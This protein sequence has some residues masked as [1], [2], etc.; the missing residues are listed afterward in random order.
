MKLLII[1]V[2]D[3]DDVKPLPLTLSAIS[4][5]ARMFQHMKVTVDLNLDQIDFFSQE[6]T[7]LERERS[8]SDTLSQLQL[9]S[10]SDENVFLIDLIT[11]TRFSRIREKH[12]TSLAEALKQSPDTLAGAAAA[13]TC[14]ADTFF[15]NRG[16]PVPD[17]PIY[18]EIQEALGIYGKFGQYRRMMKKNIQ[19][20]LKVVF[21]KLCLTFPEWKMA[22]RIQCYLT[23]AL[24][25][26]YE[27]S[28]GKFEC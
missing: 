19:E 1:S 12:G 17:W 24:S 23:A 11:S 13:W 6:I 25:N 21:D 16:R 4:L 27:F 10:D 14:F 5:H 15:R 3:W 8:S 9:N 20:H 18:V 7:R 26:E 22:A 28:S 2:I